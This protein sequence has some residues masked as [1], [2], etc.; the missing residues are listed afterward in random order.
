MTVRSARAIKIPGD[1]SSIRAVNRMKRL[2]G[3]HMVADRWNW[4]KKGM[5]LKI[6]RVGGKRAIVPCSA[7]GSVTPDKSQVGSLVRVQKLR[8]DIA[9][10]FR[11]DVGKTSAVGS[12]E[13]REHGRILHS[14]GLRV[15]VNVHDREL[16]QG[17]GLHGG[18]G[19]VGKTLS[20][21]REG[22]ECTSF[23]VCDIAVR[24]TVQCA[25]V[26]R[27]AGLAGGGVDKALPIRRDI[28]R[29]EEAAVHIDVGA[30][31]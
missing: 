15:S 6:P 3:D 5:T 14:P 13:E 25:K 7:R 29:L 2:S 20:V 22:E 30:D 27:E 18:G 21:R 28:R 4:S 12:P 10:G 31:R 9:V 16:A 1:P 11:N 23:T 19:K 26:Q 17:K 8:V 24:G